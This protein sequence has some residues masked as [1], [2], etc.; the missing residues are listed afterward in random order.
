MQQLELAAFLV[1]CAL[2]SLIPFAVLVYFIARDKGGRD[3]RFK[4]DGTG[5][6]FRVY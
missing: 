5:S 2:S 6:R 1:G 3:V 4:R